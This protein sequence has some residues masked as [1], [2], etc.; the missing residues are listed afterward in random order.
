[1]VDPIGPTVFAPY[2]MEQLPW[3][4]SLPG[5]NPP[6]LTDGSYT[7]SAERWVG[8]AVQVAQTFG[9]GYYHFVVDLL[10]RLLLGLAAAPGAAV[11]MQTDHGGAMHGYVLQWLAIAGVRPEM[12]RGLE[13]LPEAGAGGGLQGRARL[14]VRGPPPPH[15]HSN[16]KHNLP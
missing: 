8:K 2:L 7:P 12:V 5:G 15:P 16:V 6:S 3:H 13:V 1:M 10:P 11:I 14:G 9:A 4:S